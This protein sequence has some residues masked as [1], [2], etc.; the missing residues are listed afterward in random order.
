M[1]HRF[2]AALVLV[3][4]LAACKENDPGQQG[5]AFFQGQGDVRVIEA[6]IIPT[7]DSSAQM[8][9]GTLRYVLARVEFTNDLGYDLTPDITHFYLVDRNNN[10][11]QG[12]D[13]GSSVFTGVSNSTLPL[14]KDEKREY[15]VGFRTNDPNAAGTIFYE[16]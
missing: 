16:R 12:K 1:I 8:G 6:H 15:T 2:A 13:S 14:K 10:R 3:L 7:G 5:Q 4:S 11:Y 9:G